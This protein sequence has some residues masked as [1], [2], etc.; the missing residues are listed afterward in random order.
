VSTAP[1]CHIVR[2]QPSGGEHVVL[3][4]TAFLRTPS[5]WWDPLLS[6]TPN[7]LLFYDQKLK[8]AYLHRLLKVHTL[9]QQTYNILIFPKFSI[10]SLW[11]STIWVDAQ[12]AENRDWRRCRLP[13]ARGLF[14][15][16]YAVSSPTGFGAEP[17]PPEGFSLFSS[18]DGLSS[19]S[20]Y[21]LWVY[22]SWFWNKRYL[23]SS[24]CKVN[25]TGR[26]E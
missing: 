22:D 16:G 24:R 19:R 14:T 8:T 17:L 2:Q 5:V 4:A 25:E 7:A 10:G 12:R 13:P 1:L 6:D 11:S 26:A 23:K 15:L 21:N 3:W 18:Q 9:Q 20:L